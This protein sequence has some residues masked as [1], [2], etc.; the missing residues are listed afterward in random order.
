MKVWKD[1]R[2]D[3]LFQQLEVKNKTKT[4][5]M[6]PAT[7]YVHSEKIFYGK[8]HYEQDCKICE[9]Q[10]RVKK[11]TGSSALVKIG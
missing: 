5:Q 9:R 11:K 10:T 7:K 1:L 3:G 6:Q 4:P 2:M 8:S